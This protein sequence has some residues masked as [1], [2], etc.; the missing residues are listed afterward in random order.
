M[1]ELSHHF[2]EYKIVAIAIRESVEKYKHLWSTP[3]II[4][5]A[6]LKIIGIGFSEQDDTDHIDYG[7]HMSVREELHFYEEG[8]RKPFTSISLKEFAENFYY[9]Q[10]RTGLSPIQVQHKFL[11][12]MRTPLESYEI[13]KAGISEKVNKELKTLEKLCAQVMVERG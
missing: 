4:K 12:A 10:T 5:G 8:K 9:G 3:S 7:L 2:N 1:S 11:E 6:K 13:H